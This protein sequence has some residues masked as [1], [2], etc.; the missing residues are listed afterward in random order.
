MLTCESCGRVCK[1][2]RSL[3]IHIELHHRSEPGIVS[4]AVLNHAVQQDAQREAQ[5]PRREEARRAAAR[6]LG[7]PVLPALPPLPPPYF[8]DID[9]DRVFGNQRTFNFYAREELRVSLS[10]HAPLPPPLY[11]H[12]CF[13]RW[14]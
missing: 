3:C 8:G 4:R 11:T 12:A 7:E 13:A 6:K 5:R 14:S 10:L 9:V 1:N 2:Y